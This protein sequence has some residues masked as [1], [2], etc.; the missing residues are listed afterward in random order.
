MKA[1]KLVAVTLATAMVLG[2][3]LT[4]LADSSGSTGTTGT[5]TSFEHLD[6]KKLNVVFPTIETGD[7]PFAYI[8]DSERLITAA[9]GKYNGAN[10]TLPASNDTGVY[11]LTGSTEATKTYTKKSEK[12]DDADDDK[13]TAA[14]NT[15]TEEAYNELGDANVKA[16]YEETT[17]GGGSTYANTSTALT[18]TN[19]SSHKVKISATATASVESGKTMV[20][21]ADSATI[22]EST[23]PKLY[24]G[25]TVGSET[26]AITN[27]TTGVTAEAEVAGVPSNFE[28]NSTSDGKFEYKVKA[29]AVD[30]S[31]QTT[32]ISMTGACN[33]VTNVGDVVAPT[34]AVTWTYTDP[35]AT[36]AAAAPS[37]A[38]TTYNFVANTPIEVTASL[39]SGNLAAENIVGVE[40]PDGNA[41]A[42]SN[43]TISG[44][45]VTFN[46]TWVNTVSG[47][48]NDGESVKYKVVFDD[49]ATTKI[50]LTFTK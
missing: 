30:S 50:E 36:P 21:L 41:L 1:K 23:T 3:S 42:T 48:L 11:F 12:P 47:R 6:Q 16:F 2:S 40:K 38:T 20:A 22:A 34:I 32:T 17:S 49:S 44:S 33:S 18:V 7:T 39:G 9:N 14:G 46:A 25:I 5:G 10:V 31:W 4:A 29:D 24:L 45:K 43:Y 37:I 35:E 15:L 26:K 19:K 28:V 8:M 27:A 13:W